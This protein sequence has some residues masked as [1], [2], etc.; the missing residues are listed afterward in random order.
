MKIKRICLILVSVY[1]LFAFHSFAA[2]ETHFPK[3]NLQPSWCKYA[4]KL[5][6]D[7]NVPAVDDEDEV[8]VFVKDNNGNDICIGSCVIGKTYPGYFYVSVYGDDPKTTDIKEGAYEQENLLFKV[9][10][11]NKCK[12]YTVFNISSNSFSGME[13]P[14]VPPIYVETR[15]FA[16]LNLYVST[17]DDDNILPGDI[18]KNC[19]LDIKD[20]IE[21][22]TNL[23]N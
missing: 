1:Y 18:N 14:S 11:R 3:P 7:N 8:G 13:L 6:F 4:G 16:E 9:W 17:D 2:D 22:L 21:I 20:I 23:S 10:D 19:R 15:Q 12:E 5:I